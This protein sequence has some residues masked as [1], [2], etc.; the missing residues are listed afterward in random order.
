[1]HEDLHI[2]AA[3]ADDMEDDEEEELWSRTIQPCL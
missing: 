2:H 3:I 1:V